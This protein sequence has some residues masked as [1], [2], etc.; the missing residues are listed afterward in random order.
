[1]YK[2]LGYDCATAVLA[3]ITL[4]IVPFPYVALARKDRKLKLI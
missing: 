2:K 1:V 4:A 3:F